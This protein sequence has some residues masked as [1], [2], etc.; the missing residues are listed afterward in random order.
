MK[1]QRHMVITVIIKLGMLCLGSAGTKKNHKTRVT[2][3]EKNEFR[4]Q[5]LLRFQL[6]YSCYFIKVNYEVLTAVHCSLSF[7]CTHFRGHHV[8][9]PLLLIYFCVCSSSCLYFTYEFSHWHILFTTE[10]QI[11]GKQNYWN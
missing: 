11:L 2:K 9:L 3:V 5:L 6:G 8:K 10:H 7:Q 1:W 4:V